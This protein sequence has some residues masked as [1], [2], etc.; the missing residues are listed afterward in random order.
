LAVSKIFF[1]GIPASPSWEKVFPS[2]W[3]DDLPLAGLLKTEILEILGIPYLINDKRTR[4][5]QIL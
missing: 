5:F 3:E 1:Y 4:P 2:I